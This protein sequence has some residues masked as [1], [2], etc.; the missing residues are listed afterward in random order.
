MIWTMCGRGRRGGL[1]QRCAP[2]NDGLFV[3]ASQPYPARHRTRTLNKEAVTASHPYPARYRTRTLNR[4]FVIASEAWR[5]M[6]S[7]DMDCV[8]SFAMTG[9]FMES[10]ARQSMLLEVM[11]CFTSFAMTATVAMTAAFAMTGN[12]CRC[13][14]SAVV[15]T[16]P[17]CYALVLPTI[18]LIYKGFST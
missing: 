2:R 7:G 11:D 18:N 12:T 8:T 16:N 6:T 10:E 1:P 3:I 13:P 9:M 17:L 14:E 4:D 15:V 5:S